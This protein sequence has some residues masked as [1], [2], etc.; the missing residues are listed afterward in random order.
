MGAFLLLSLDRVGDQVRSRVMGELRSEVRLLAETL[1]E[2]GYGGVLDRLAGILDARITIIGADGGVRYDSE[3]DVTRMENHATRPELVE[4][5]EGGVAVVQRYSR[6]VKRELIYA[7][8]RLPGGR[9]FVRLARDES[10]VEGELARIARTFWFVAAGVVVVGALFALV[11]AKRVTR[12][13]MRLTEAA[14]ARARGGHPEAV[15]PVGGD[16]VARLGEAF[17]EMTERLD[18]TIASAKS[19]AARLLA[20]LGGMSEG[21]LA[22]D[23]EERIAFH[24][25]A[26]ERILGLQLPVEGDRLYQHVREPRILDLVQAVAKGKE[27]LDAEISHEGPPRRMIQVYVAPAG[28]DV[29]IVLGDLSRMRRLERMRTDF[30]SSVSHELRTPLA[31]IAA[32]IET[33]ED[34]EVRADPGTGA[35]N[36]LDPA[37]C[38][39]GVRDFI[40]WWIG[41]N[42]ES[43]EW[44]VRCCE[45]IEWNRYL[46]VDYVTGR[47]DV[48]L[49]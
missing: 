46:D 30:V 9:G 36:G 13:L 6:T 24:N 44:P 45:P 40:H 4:A 28:T 2:S 41:R 17:N 42:D 27:P 33:L 3:S 21:V 16:E 29:I 10:S 23:A 11:F 47:F 5:R 20:I 14:V 8:A 18:E 25:R 43:E 48:P 12:P 1:P 32:A 37:A 34:P 19:E 49:P 7:A 31:S 15:S 39:T 22:V 35:N 26:A 38:P